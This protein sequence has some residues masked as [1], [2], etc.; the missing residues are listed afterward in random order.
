MSHNKIYYREASLQFIDQIYIRLWFSEPPFASV[1]YL[2]SRS[3]AQWCG[4]S[5]ADAPLRNG[6]GGACPAAFLEN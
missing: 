1:F 4:G 5:K 3:R 2:S 6:G